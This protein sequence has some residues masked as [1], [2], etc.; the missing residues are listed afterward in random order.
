MGGMR[1]LA[2]LGLV[3]GC[4]GGGDRC[5]RMVEKLVPGVGGIAKDEAV[6]ECR[7]DLRENPERIKMID[8]VLA[9]GPTS[10]ASMAECARLDEGGDDGVADN[11][12]IAKPSG[13][14][15]PEVM[16]KLRGIK[17]QVCACK[18]L[19]CAMRA[20][21]QI[22]IYSAVLWTEETYQQLT[23]DERLQVERNDDQVT[24]CVEKLEPQ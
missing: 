10:A 13:L 5:E 20:K 3:V 1:F 8:C 6:R 9:S 2:I 15:K 18:D 19:D 24:A 17:D 16:P 12:P 14:L 23:L 21:E 7:D 11:P 4:G 22:R